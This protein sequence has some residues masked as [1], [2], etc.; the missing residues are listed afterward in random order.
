VDRVMIT[1]D[2]ASYST[3]IHV[4]L[5]ETGS[6]T[7]VFEGAVPLSSTGSGDNSLHV[8]GG[9]SITVKYLDLAPGDVLVERV[10]TAA[11]A[12]VALAPVSVTEPTVSI[13]DISQTVAPG[14][15]FDVDVWVEPVGG[16]VSAASIVLAFDPAA[17]HVDH[18]GMGSFLGDGPI[19]APGYPKIDND[20][21]TVEIDAAR[22][23]AT[24]PPTESNTFARITL[25]AT[26]D[27][28]LRGVYSLVPA[29]AELADENALDIPRVVARGG[30]V[31]I[32]EPKEI[33]PLKPGA[34]DEI[35]E[36]ESEGE[37]SEEDDYARWDLNK[38]CTV[39]EEDLA[40]LGSF[41]GRATQPPYPRADVN[42]D[43][44]VDV[45]DLSLIA[46]H[47]GETRGPCSDD[48]NEKTASPWTEWW[49]Q[50]QRSTK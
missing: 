10:A 43:S 17:M 4:E 49:E 11:V 1:V 38:D 30:T 46:A 6:N 31:V 13:R 42:E 5:L 37:A 16:G 9:D 35:A 8:M 45:K 40:I 36:A 24:S 14:E 18:V 47:W 2:S 33:L 21:G 22:K 39:D 41:Y 28:N 44:Q 26:D 50:F 29:K 20:V 48:I 19:V 3:G 7:G 34:L 12:P 32:A 15:S 27:W 23:G 25:T